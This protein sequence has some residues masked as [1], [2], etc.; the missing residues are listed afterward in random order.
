MQQVVLKL[1]VGKPPFV[2]IVYPNSGVV[3]SVVNIDLVKDKRY[4]GAV[5]KLLIEFE[6]YSIRLKLMC[7]ERLVIRDYVDLTVD[8]KE[9]RAWYQVA[10]FSPFINFGHVTKDNHKDVILK[11][12]ARQ[13]IVFK[14][15][16]LQLLTGIPV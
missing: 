11:V 7:L 14:V 2:G 1:P 3:P 16:E 9:F 8:L 10:R 5:Y 12:N 6:G 13:P 4:Q 15:D